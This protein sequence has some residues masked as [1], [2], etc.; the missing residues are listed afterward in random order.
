M[1][2]PFGPHTEYPVLTSDGV[3]TEIAYFDTG[4]L[5][6]TTFLASLDRTGVPVGAPRAL[7]PTTHVLG[8]AVDAN[9]RAVAL[10][11]DHWIALEALPLEADD[12]LDA[13]VS[14]GGDAAMVT[15]GALARLGSE[16][17]AAWIGD[18]CEGRPYLARL[19]P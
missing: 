2:T 19:A 4:G 16:L 17:V 15:G 7:D 12:S 3:R 14:L 8:L 1:Q 11:A 13:P 18:G 5:S 6:G 9:E 10:A